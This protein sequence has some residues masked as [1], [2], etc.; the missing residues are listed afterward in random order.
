MKIRKV[1]AIV[2]MALSIF[3]LTGCATIESYRIVDSDYSITDGIVITL[4]KKELGAKYDDVKQSVVRDM[5]SFSQYVSKWID[6]FEDDHALIHSLLKKGITC[7][8]VETEKD[9]QLKFIMKFSGIEYFRF[10]YG[11]ECV[12]EELQDI[13]L[14]EEYERALEDIGPFVANMSAGEYGRENMGLFLYKYY[15]FDSSGIMSGIGNCCEDIGVRDYVEKYSSMTG[16]T[17]DDVDITQAFTYPDDSL[18][19]NADDVEKVGG[20]TFMSWDISEK[21]DDFKMEIYYLGARPTAWYVLALVLTAGA[22]V[23]IYFYIKKKHNGERPQIT[24]QEIESN[25]R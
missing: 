15:M 24:K 4:D 13:M 16:Y 17:L 19:S 25:G 23:G 14:A 12:T 3:V 18:C 21:D 2:C 1:M 6:S 9:N 22:T 5:M 10:F 11:L 7:G 8:M 20:M